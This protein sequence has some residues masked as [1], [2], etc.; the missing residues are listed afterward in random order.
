MA[1]IAERVRRY[2]GVLLHTDAVQAAPYLPIDLDELD[3]DLL[4]IAAH[5]F[6]GPKGA[7]ALFVRHGTNMLVQQQG[8]AQER[9]RRAGT[10]DVAGAAGMGRALELAVAER[11]ETT[12]RIGELRAALMSAV[13][14]D[15]AVQMTGHPTERLPGIAS[16]LVPGLDGTALTIALDLAGVAASTGSACVSGS[17][18]ISHVLTAMGYTDDEARG[19]LRFSLGRTTTA[20]E[21]AQ[22]SDLI[23]K[24]IAHQREAATKLADGAPVGKNELAV[25]EHTGVSAG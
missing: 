8:G 24:T 11:D 21:V 19:A 16:F 25:A 15:A 4:S 23:V 9:Y 14:A 6:E 13:G 18:E 10:E 2:K 7:G 20:E 1:E 3:V 5:K 22:A 12:T 17:N